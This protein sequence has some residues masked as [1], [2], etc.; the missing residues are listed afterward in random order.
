M[1][2]VD[3]IV[4]V[5][6]AV[7]GAI[8]GLATSRYYYLKQKQEAQEESQ[9]QKDRSE[10][11][12]NA[13]REAR[14]EF[15]KLDKERR[16]YSWGAVGDGCRR[17]AN[18]CIEPFE[19]AAI[20]TLSG[21]GSVV[22]SLALVEVEY[23]LPLYTVIQIRKEQGKANRIPK[24]PGYSKTATTQTWF[25]FF[26]DALEYITDKKLVVIDDCVLTGELLREVRRILTDEL[27]FESDNVRTAVLVYS[28]RVVGRAGIKP[29]FAAYSSTF[30]DF[31]LPW[32]PPV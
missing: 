29:D 30:T 2:L 21:T 7:V 6:L 20:L 3:I 18:E 16:S 10:N 12:E 14:T 8:L 28:E 4:G 24:I 25:L 19:P 9:R 5:G 15:E 31:Y 1:T 23:S 27:G 11:L 17:L 32:G 26:P 22:A 13:L